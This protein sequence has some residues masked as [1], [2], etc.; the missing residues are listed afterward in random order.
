MGGLD[1]LQRYQL[2]SYISAL[3]LFVLPKLCHESAWALNGIFMFNLVIQNVLTS[4]AIY[5]LGR[6][7]CSLLTHGECHRDY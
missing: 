5:R 4:K 2:Y 6:M 7:C 3:T 1:L